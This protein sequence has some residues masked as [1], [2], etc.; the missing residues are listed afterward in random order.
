MHALVG[1]CTD[2]WMYVLMDGWVDGWMVG[3]WTDEWTEVIDICVQ[4]TDM[5]TTQVALSL[6]L[7]AQGSEPLSWDSRP[8]M[9]ICPP[10]PVASG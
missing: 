4:G 7:P 3:G 2:A 8:L 5:S 1:G 6:P 9:P 10:A